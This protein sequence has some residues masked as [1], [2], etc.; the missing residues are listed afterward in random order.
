MKYKCSICGYEYDEAKEGI[1][2]ADLPEDW[3]C[4]WCKAPKSA[5]EPIEEAETVAPVQVSVSDISNEIPDESLQQL[6]IGQMAAL[7]SNL[8]RGCEKQYMTEEQ[9]LFNELAEWF[10]SH[11]PKVEDATVEAITAHLQQDITNYPLLNQTCAAEA[12]RGAL[13]V[14]SWSEKATRML[15]SLISRYQRESDALL[16]DTEIWVCSVCGFVYIGKEA[17]ELCPIC[18]VPSWKFNKIEGRKQS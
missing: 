16:A 12:D 10:T 17:P 8:A 13:R 14:L 7:C 18:K 6:S 3:Q 15:S 9:N 11:S 5:F 4:P 2:F 1:T